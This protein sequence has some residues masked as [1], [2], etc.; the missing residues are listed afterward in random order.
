SQSQVGSAVQLFTVDIKKQGLV[1]RQEPS[2]SGEVVTNIEPGT[3]TIVETTQKEG[4]SWGRLKSGQG[5]IS[6]G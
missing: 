2:L 6:F 5:W 3:Y 1:I 4:H